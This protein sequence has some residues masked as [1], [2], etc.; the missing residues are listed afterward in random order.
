MN[1]FVKQSSPFIRVIS[2]P[3]KHSSYNQTTLISCYILFYILK[4]IP[5]N[6]AQTAEQSLYDVTLYKRYPVYIHTKELC[7]SLIA[8][9][10]NVRNKIPQRPE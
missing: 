5:E 8:W 4:S 10:T 2:I 6:L 9:P 1:R 3:R 7:F